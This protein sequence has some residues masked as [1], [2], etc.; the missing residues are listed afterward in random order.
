VAFCTVFWTNRSVD[1]I[2]IDMRL[3]SSPAI[4]CAVALATVLVAGCE[5]GPDESAAFEVRDSSGVRIVES[6]AA[7]WNEL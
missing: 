7:I 2:F 6:R 5:T 1:P 4:D 3:F